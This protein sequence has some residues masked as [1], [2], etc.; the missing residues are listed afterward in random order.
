MEK[1]TDKG[2]EYKEVDRDFSS[3]VLPILDRE[4][5]NGWELVATHTGIKGKNM[6]MIFKRKVK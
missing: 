6:T 4:E 2:W 3:P 5:Q 1:T